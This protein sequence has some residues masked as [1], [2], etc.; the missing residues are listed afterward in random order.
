MYIEMLS[1]GAILL[2]LMPMEKGTIY[3]KRPAPG[4]NADEREVMMVGLQHLREKERKRALLKETL[5]KLRI[6][7]RTVLL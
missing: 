4:K 5:P 1:Y 6:C 7:L 2:R 3:W